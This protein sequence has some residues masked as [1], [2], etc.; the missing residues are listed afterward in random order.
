MENVILKEE[1]GIAEIIINRPKALNALNSETLKELGSIIDDIHVNDNIKAVIITGSGEKSFVAGAD[2]AQM[3]KLNSIEAAKFSRLAQNVFSKIENLPKLVIAA[4][5]GFALGGGCELA[6]AC[7]IRFASKKAKFGQPEVNLGILPSFGGTQRLPRLVGKG[8]AKELIFSTDMISA[9]E[10]Y[11]IG[12]ANKVYEPEELLTKAKEFAQK[13][14]TKS[15]VGVRLAK[16]SINNG[17]DVDLEAGLK[18][19]ANSFGLCFST[20]DQKEGMK[21]FLEKRKANFKDC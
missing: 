4:V 21:A 8:I 12:L 13:V 15:P 2:I 19:E 3:S 16:A 11:R 14:M 9:N 20:E 6:M 17:L 1:N 7:D 18:Y 10:A 5:N